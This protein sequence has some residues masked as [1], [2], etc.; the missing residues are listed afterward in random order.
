MMWYIITTSLLLI[1]IHAT[2]E[3]WMDKFS[4][5]T[6]EGNVVPFKDYGDFSAILIVN[7]ASECGYTDSNYRELQVSKVF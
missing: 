5:E 2:A 1:L 4:V 3:Q 6:I 7:V